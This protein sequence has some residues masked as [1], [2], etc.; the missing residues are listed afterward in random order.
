MVG[1][2]LEQRIHSFKKKIYLE[3]KV[4][5]GENRQRTSKQVN[6]NLLA[7]S[8]NGC[9]GW[10]WFLTSMAGTQVF[11]PYS[12][13]FPRHK[14]WSEVKH[15]G[16]KSASIWDA[17]VGCSLTHYDT[18][19]VPRIHFKEE[20]RKPATDLCGGRFERFFSNEMNFSFVRVSREWIWKRNSKTLA[21]SRK[22]E[23][24]VEFLC[25]GGLGGIP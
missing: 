18:T 20:R 2:T 1:L 7:Y 22:I 9:N 14:A 16:L 17:N 24:I 15:L 23:A 12:T 25:V 6:S 21:E 5:E 10:G 8:L 4:R 19:V 11:G 3:S 13:A